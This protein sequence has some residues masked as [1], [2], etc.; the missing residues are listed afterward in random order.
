MFDRLQDLSTFSTE[1][2]QIIV[3]NLEYNLFFMNS[4]IQKLFGIVVK[5]QQLRFTF[6]LYTLEAQ[7]LSFQLKNNPK[8]IHLILFVSRL[9]RQ[10]VS[11]KYPAS[12]GRAMASS[13]LNIDSYASSQTVYRLLLLLRHLAL[14]SIKHFSLSS[15]HFLNISLIFLG[16]FVV[17]L[18]Y[19]FPYPSRSRRNT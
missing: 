11:F 9:S 2:G 13:R 16:T 15:D 1:V 10:F 7:L 8:Y 3:V 19:L 6:V 4:R 5:K 12:Y 17:R 18:S 14:I